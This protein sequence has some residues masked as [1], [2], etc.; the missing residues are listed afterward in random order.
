MALIKFWLKL[1]RT[2][3]AT[4]LGLIVICVFMAAVMRTVG[5]PIIWSV[6]IAQLLFVWVCMLGGNQAMHSGD[7]VGIDYFVK[8]FSRKV[9]LGIDAAMYALILF[10]LAALIVYGIKLTLLNPERELG[11][12]RLPYSLVTAAIPLGG[13]LMFCTAAAQFVYIIRVLL[14]QVDADYSLSFMQKFVADSDPVAPAQA[15]L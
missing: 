12:V 5:L 4:L 15:K 13:A 8:R 1:E 2:V 3:V 6:D 10:F 7:H 11:A 9:Q 14:G